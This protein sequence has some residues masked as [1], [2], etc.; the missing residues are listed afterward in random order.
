MAGGGGF[1]EADGGFEGELI[2]RVEG[3]LDVSGLDG[4]A[5]RVDTRFDLSEEN[6]AEVVGQLGGWWKKGG[7]L[8]A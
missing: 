6:S 4:S 7:S 8:T 2:E 5:G 1:T 3:V